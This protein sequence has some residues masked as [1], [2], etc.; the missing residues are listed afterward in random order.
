ML[1]EFVS[2]SHTQFWGYRC[3]QKAPHNTYDKNNHRA[4]HGNWPWDVCPQLQE[5]HLNQ[6]ELYGLSN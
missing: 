4:E 3:I 1:E 2:L 5:A 6:A